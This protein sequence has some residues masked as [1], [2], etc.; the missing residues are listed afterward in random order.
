MN[1]NLLTDW[2][3]VRPL[4]QSFYP[5]DSGMFCF[6]RRPL[7]GLHRLLLNETY[8]PVHILKPGQR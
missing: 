2:R 1:N 6:L 3:L 5:D 8:E 4:G 7:N